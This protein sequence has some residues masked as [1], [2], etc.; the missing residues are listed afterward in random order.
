MTDVLAERFFESPVIADDVTE[1]AKG[2]AGCLDDWNVNWRGSYL[3][4]DGKRMI[5]HFESV[6]VES[7][8]MALRQAGW[9]GEVKV[10]PITIHEKTSQLPRT[11]VVERYF[12]EPT[13]LQALQ[14]VEDASAWCLDKYEVKFV[15]TF[16]SLDRK[17][18]LCFYDASDAESVR[19]AQREASMPF[20]KVWPCERIRPKAT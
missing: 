18:M 5:C 20:E 16:F 10:W 1:M 13:E 19:Q 2:G 7:V 14:D 15:A 3:V 6:D 9:Q 8:R 17:Q 4:P 11:I 12:D